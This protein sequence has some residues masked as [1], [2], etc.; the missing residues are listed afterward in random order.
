MSAGSTTAAL[1]DRLD[2]PPDR[3]ADPDAAS[4]PAPSRAGRLLGLVRKL[5]DYG[6]DLAHTLQ[7]RTAATALFT[8]ALQ[9]GTRDIALILAR[10]TRGLR[11]AN[12]LEARLVSHPVR[13]EVAVPALV[14][15]P[16]DRKPRTA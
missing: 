7:Q 6:K 12:A 11:L 13:E 15:A 4:A 3:A 14:R 10:I 5:I 8:V 9:F 1:P 16:S 2:P